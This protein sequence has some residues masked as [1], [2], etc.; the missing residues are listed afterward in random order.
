M[1]SIL[2][3]FVNSWKFVAIIVVVAFFVIF[4]KSLNVPI[5]KLSLEKIINKIIKLRDR[6]KA[7][8]KEPSKEDAVQIK[9]FFDDIKVKNFNEFYN[10]LTEYVQSS[11]QTKTKVLELEKQN[12]EL[13]NLWKIYM[14][15]YLDLFLVY[16]SKS[17]LLWFYN[18]PWITKK[19]FVDNFELANVLIGQDNQKEIIFTVLLQN[20]LLVKDD[21][22]LYTI[23]NMGVD[24]LTITNFIKQNDKN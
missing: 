2:S 23:T 10:Q 19:Y 3:N 6:N 14:F 18:H 21:R 1:L 17:A 4:K 9:K 22:D 12:Q 20:F 5:R 13:F 7:Q 16:N 11:E 8:G 24:F 15:S